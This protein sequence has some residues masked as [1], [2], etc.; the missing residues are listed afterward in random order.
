FG[1]E[2]YD[3]VEGISLLDMVAP[4]YVEEFKQLLKSLGKGE[5]APPQYEIHAR[6]QEGDIF[7]AT[8]E[9]SPATYEGESC[10]QVVFRRREEFDPELAREVEELRQRDQV[11]GL[12]NRPTFMVHLENA[13]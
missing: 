8:M 9:F 1:Y 11:T 5:A 3:D 4:Q 13:V 7:P 10:F 12:L 6:N 2:S